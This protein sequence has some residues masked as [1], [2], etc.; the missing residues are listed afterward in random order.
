MPKMYRVVSGDSC[1]WEFIDTDQNDK[2]LARSTEP[3][4]DDDDA[5]K[6]IKELK[7]ATKVKKTNGQD[8][9]LPAAS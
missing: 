6:A 8:I 1:H 2:V 7:K 9:E 4:G 3:L 5:I